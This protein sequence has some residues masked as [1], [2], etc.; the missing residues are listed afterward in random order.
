[1]LIKSTLISY[2]FYS[3]YIKQNQK[4]HVLRKS[5][6]HRSYVT[7]LPKDQF[8][9]NPLFKVCPTL[10]TIEGGHTHDFYIILDRNDNL[11]QV[12]QAIILVFYIL[13]KQF[14]MLHKPLLIKI[15]LTTY[16]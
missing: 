4:K 15:N 8:I 11:S 9:S 13:I 1:M 5:N 7:N 16:K 10:E 2:A 12:A 6:Q 14:I 3:I